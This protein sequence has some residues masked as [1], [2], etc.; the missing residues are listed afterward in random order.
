MGDDI[1]DEE[2]ND[3]H[4]RNTSKEKVQDSTLN[5]PAKKTKVND[6]IYRWRNVSPSVFDTSFGGEE[7]D[8]PLENFEELTPLSYFQMFW[9]KDLNK[10]IAEQTN[11]NSVQKDG[12]S[13]ATTEDEIKQFISIQMLMSLVDLPSYMM[14]WA[15]ETR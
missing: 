11:L 9:N 13:I 3:N 8:V 14:Y 5:Q 4:E 1:S 12:K 10:L 7:F 2:V 15:R 6:H